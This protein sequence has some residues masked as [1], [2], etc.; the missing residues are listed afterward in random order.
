[1]DIDRRISSFYRE[2]RQCLRFS[3]HRYNNIL[4]YQE[5]ALSFQ[6]QLDDERRRRQDSERQNKELCSKNQNLQLHIRWLMD[7]SDS[8]VEWKRS[9]EGRCSQ[10]ENTNISLY[11]QNQELTCRCTKIAAENREL[12]KNY[13][14]LVRSFQVTDDD[15]STIYKRLLGLRM[16]IESLVQRA[17]GTNSANMIK[18]VA[19]QYLRDS[20]LLQEFPIGENLLDAYHM[21]IYMET[22]I[23]KILND[24]LFK[25]PFAC[26]FDP[27]MGFEGIYEWIKTRDS[28]MAARWRQQMCLLT[29]QDANTFESKREAEVKR[30]ITALSGL[31]ST[32]YPKAEITPKTTKLCYEAFDLNY[33]MFGLESMIYPVS[34]PRGT[35]FNEKTMTTPQKS[36]P[37]GSVSLEIFP[38][39]QDSDGVFYFQPKVWCL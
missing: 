9:I 27:N 29:A 30:V 18:G 28:K 4:R 21:S 20:G 14:S 22:A 33:A 13:M 1:M 19:I 17:K 15:S 38:S 39:F 31:L 10:L 25:K 7:Q 2:R 12:N 11:Q 5:S 36:N 26:I 24:R 32:V 37:A 23:M 8:G 34:T 16:S 35:P 6:R 3:N